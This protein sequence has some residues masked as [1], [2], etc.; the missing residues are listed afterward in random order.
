MS[1]PSAIGSGTDVAAKRDWRYVLQLRFRTLALR[2]ELQKLANQERR[3]LNEI[4][5]MACEEFV[6]GRKGQS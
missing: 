6:R 3:S 1:T 5:N 2:D 4:I